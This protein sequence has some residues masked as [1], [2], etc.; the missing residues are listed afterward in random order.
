MY[1]VAYLHV[2]IDTFYIILNFV[3]FIGREADE[4]GSDIDSLPE[5]IETECLD[6]NGDHKLSQS[7]KRRKMSEEITEAKVTA[8][9]LK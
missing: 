5:N 3:Y 6:E 8:C 7:V 2:Y 9:K 1:V 4:T